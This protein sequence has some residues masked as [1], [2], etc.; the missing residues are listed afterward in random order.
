MLL[1]KDEKKFNQKFKIRQSNGKYT[2]SSSAQTFIQVPNQTTTQGVQLVA[3]KSTDSFG[4][5]WQII[6]KKGAKDQYTR[7]SFCGKY[8]ALAEGKTVNGGEVIQWNETKDTDQL[9]VIVPC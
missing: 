4:E 3:A 7:N 2:I 8:L 5:K 6:P 1:W 9:W